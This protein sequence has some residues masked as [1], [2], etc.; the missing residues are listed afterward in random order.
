M[1][2]KR[3]AELAEDLLAAL[4]RLT[5]AVEMV[6]ISHLVDRPDS[7]HVRQVFLGE[8]ELAGLEVKKSFFRFRAVFGLE[9]LTPYNDLV[10]GQNRILAD[11]GLV[12]AT[13]P[14]DP[15]DGQRLMDDAIKKMEVTCRAAIRA[16]KRHWWQWGWPSAAARATPSMARFIAASIASRSSALRVRTC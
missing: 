1:T 14:G 13:E 15:K 7:T 5:D 2:G 8:F 4:Y 11:F 12:P 6:G 10:R 9:A 3:R 16:E